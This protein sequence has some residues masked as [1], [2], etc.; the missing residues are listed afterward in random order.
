MVELGE[1][2]EINKRDIN[3]SGKKES[4]SNIR[5]IAQAAEKS[6][7]RALPVGLV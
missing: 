5:M 2:P 7:E 1:S 6:V 3:N 4:H